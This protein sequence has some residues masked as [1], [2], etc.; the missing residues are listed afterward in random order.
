[1][2]LEHNNAVFSSDRF[3]DSMENLISRIEKKWCLFNLSS[4]LRLEADFERI[5][6]SLG[7][8]LFYLKY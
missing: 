7:S 6:V 4:R 3:I 5:T 8:R 2:F 1:M